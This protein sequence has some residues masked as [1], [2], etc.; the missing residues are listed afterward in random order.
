[1]PSDQERLAT[2]EADRRTEREFQR[3]AMAKLDKLED[4]VREL[5]NKVGGAF[6]GL[7]VL[8]AVA[9]GMGVIAGWVLKAL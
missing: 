7:R 5:E 4:A 9:A 1:M 6:A 8:A 3:R 2:L